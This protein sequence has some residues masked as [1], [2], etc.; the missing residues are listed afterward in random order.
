MS[1][2]VPL[3]LP[4]AMADSGDPPLQDDA[5]G[6]VPAEFDYVAHLDWLIF[7]QSPPHEENPS[8]EGSVPAD[9]D[10]EAHLEW[11]IFEQSPPH[12]KNP[13]ARQFPRWQ[14]PATCVRQMVCKALSTPT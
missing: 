9:F 7:E 8:A 5:P 14:H 3:L 13:S 6:S 1:A 4:A 10:Y 2:A 11:L 12:E